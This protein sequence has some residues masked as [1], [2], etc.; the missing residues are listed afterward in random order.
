MSVVLRFFTSFIILLAIFPFPG[1]S[2]NI[3]ADKSILEN[4]AKLPNLG[5]NREAKGK[6]IN[7]KECS[8]IILFLFKN[9]F[10]SFQHL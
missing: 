4:T 5:N 8:D 1:N 2:E 6:K 7:V 3:L 9:F 10:F